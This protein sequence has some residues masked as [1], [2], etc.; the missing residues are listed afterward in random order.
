MSPRLRDR[1]ETEANRLLR[2]RVV[3]LRHL[4]DDA[5]KSLTEPLEV[6]LTPGEWGAAEGS[7]DLQSLRDGV[8]AI[9]RGAGQREILT[10]LLDTAAAF[11]PRTA[12]FIVKG[13]TLHGW[14]GLGFMGE[15]GFRSEHLARLTLPAAG[16]HLLAQALQRRSL[17]RSGPE[18]P[19]SELV[20]ALGGVAAIEAVT[21]P[22]VVRGRPVA[23]LYADIGSERV[24]CQPLALEI[25]TRFAA[26]AMERLAGAADRP[27]PTGATANEGI[28]GATPA[29]SQAGRAGL[30]TPPEEAEMQALLGEL[31]PHPQR[32][33]GDTGLS[34]EE[35]RRLA[36]AKRFARLLVSELLL[37]NEEAV[38]QGRKNRD[39]A[40]RLEKEIDR[41][42][43]A[44][45]ARVPE[46]RGQAAEYFD[47][48]LV[49][50]LA[51][52]D[53][54]LLGR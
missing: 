14:A 40:A 4:L 35:R 9:G 10:S 24:A 23:I 38:V 12:L 54:S 41:S 20:A 17:S 52:G 25:T 27:Q 48:E 29:R 51:Q 21:I 39:L 36:D 16:T 18:G 2:E 26:L 15:N 43:Q 50:V 30:P 32:R 13:S 11:Y 34:D 31:E 7:A 1:V 8:E 46:R 53:P 37:Y 28:A 47:E 42:R 3:R 45:E 49:R 44:Y 6:P 5:L 19:G 22:V 33:A